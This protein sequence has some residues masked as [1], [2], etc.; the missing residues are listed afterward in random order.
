[1][2]G[3]KRYRI[4]D[5]LKVVD[6]EELSTTFRTMFVTSPLLGVHACADTLFP[7]RARCTAE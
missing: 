1:M 3:Q 4:A 7:P 2:I 5:F 6:N